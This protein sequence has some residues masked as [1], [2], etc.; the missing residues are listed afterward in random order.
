LCVLVNNQI[1]VPL[2]ASEVSKSISNRGIFFEVANYL[3]EAFKSL[4]NSIL[5]GSHTFDCLLSHPRNFQYFNELLIYT[6]LL[7]VLQLICTLATIQMYAAY[8][9]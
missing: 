3:Q 5:S 4:I 2:L 1:I 7:A 6:L 8:L 9:K